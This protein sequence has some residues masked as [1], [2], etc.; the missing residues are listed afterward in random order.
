[1]IFKL[2]KRD[3]S[4]NQKSNSKNN[5]T[6]QSVV[7]NNNDNLMVDM[8]NHLLEMKDTINEMG[9]RFD[10]RLKVIEKRQKKNYTKLNKLSKAFGHY[11]DNNGV[12]PE[13]KAQVK[14]MLK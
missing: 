3:N 2:R 1:M 6:N 9:N 10:N 12:A 13:V 4:V 8:V 5:N 7:V 11:V 14:E